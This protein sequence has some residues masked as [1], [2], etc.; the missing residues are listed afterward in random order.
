MKSRRVKMNSVDQK[1]IST[2]VKGALVHVVILSV[3]SMAGH[4]STAALSSSVGAVGT[5]IAPPIG[6][7][8]LI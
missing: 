8:F 1:S 7:M 4:F 2:K 3:I 5:S 6:G